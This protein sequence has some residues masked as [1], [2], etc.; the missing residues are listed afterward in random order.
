MG[1]STVIQKFRI[2]QW[3]I[4]TEMKGQYLMSYLT[5]I[6]PTTLKIY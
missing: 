4:T 2:D 6:N 3:H 5:H 1:G